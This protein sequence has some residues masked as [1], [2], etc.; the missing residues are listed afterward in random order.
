M[1]GLALGLIALAITMSLLLLRVHIGI[2][3]L[4]GGAACFWAVNDGDLSSLLFT[5]NDLAY[6]RLSNYDLAVIPLFVLMGQFAT[7][8]GLSRAIF[9]CASAF[10]G[11]WKGGMGLSA[12]GACA[13]FGAICGSSLATAATMS[14]VALPELRRH[15]YSGRLATATVAAGGTLGILI[16]PSV[17]LII[18]A[19]LTQE[20]IAKL[21]VAAIVPGVIAILGYMLV[22]RIMVARD[23]SQATVS[24]RASTAER[25]RA[26][27]CVSPVIGVFL[28]VIV[29]IYGGW[30]NPTEAA[31]IGAAACGV[32]AMLQGGMRWSG[33]RA[34]LLG[35][36]ETTA[37]IF[38]VLLGADLLNSGLALTQMP[39]ELAA[40]VIGSGLAPMLV[41]I[42]ILALYLLLGCVMDSLAMILLTIPIF[43]PMIMGLD[44]FGL[45]ETEKSIWFGILALMVV[46]IGLIHPPLGMNLFIVQRAAGDVPY[47]ETA[48]GIVPFLCS[49]LVRIALLVA[50]PGLS[51][52][53]LSL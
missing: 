16:P 39:G 5:L 1:S 27:L 48:R 37:M 3:M 24:P 34:S 10:I 23:E 15:N 47:G 43:Y 12:I 52:W 6:S 8:G 51:L 21:F 9:R 49:D 33:L 28:V 14:H 31:S 19:V 26:L 18:Y 2:T 30:A 46:E 17:P 13:G 32:L 7:H 22:L 50:F 42:L 29:G 53:L 11:H 4:V 45:G 41:L 20:S 25:L 35:T 36:A 40:W 38:L 44:F